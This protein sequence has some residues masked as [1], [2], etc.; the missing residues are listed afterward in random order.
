LSGSGET[1]H[2][3]RRLLARL[4]ALLLIAPSVSVL[5]QSLAHAASACGASTVT[6]TRTSSPVLWEDT[7]T[8]PLVNSMYEAY[9]ITNTSGSA[10]PD[11]WVTTQDFG[12]TAK[13]KPATYESGRTHLGALAAG[14]SK[15]AFFYVT[16]SVTAKNQ[17][18]T[19]AESHNIG[20]YTTRPDLAAGPLCTTASSMY[21]D[22]SQNALANK[23]TSVVSGPKPPQLGGIMTITVSGNTGTV[24]G[25]GTFVTSPAVYPTWPASSYQLTASTIVMTS[26]SATGNNRTDNDTLY[27]VG[28][29]SADSAYTATF[30]FVATGATT[31][32]TTV[33]PMS[34]I[35]SGGLMK[36]TA[37]STT[38][39]A[40][41]PIDP[42]V[43]KLSVTGTL[44]PTSL[45][46]TGGTSTWTL[47][48]KNTGN[49]A[50]TLD[51]ITLGVPTSPGIPAYAGGATF[52]GAAVTGAQTS[53]AS[54]VFPGTWT[55]P[56][57]GTSTFVVP[58][59]LPAASGSYALTAIGHVGS[60]QIDTTEDATDSAAQSRSVT[61]SLPPP[62]VASVTPS[63]GIS[64]GGTSVTVTGTNFTGATAVSFG[65]NAAS[66]FT[67][68]DATHL[69]ATAPS[70]TPLSTV[71]VRV[72][73]GSGTSVVNAADRYSYNAAPNNPPAFTAAA[74]NT[75]QTIHEADGLVQ[76][77]ATDPDG[78]SLTYSTTDPLP[79]GITLTPAGAFSGTAA[80]GS[81]GSYPVVVTVDDGQAAGN[82]TATTSLTIT[83]VAP[84]AAHLSVASPTN[85]PTPDITAT[86][87]AADTAVATLTIGGQTYTTAPSAGALVFHVSTPLG[88]GSYAVNLSVD[89]GL[90]TPATDSATLVVDT[91]P[92]TLTLALP[93]ST[94][95]TTPTISGSTNA[96]PGAIVTVS[97]NGHTYTGPVSASGTFDIDVTDLLTD[98]S[99]AVSAT[100]SDLA[101]N[102]AAATA[103]LVVSTFVPTVTLDHGSL[104]LTQDSSP[105]ISGTTDAADG[106]I[107]SVDVGGLSV[108]GTVS[109]GAF[110]VAVGTT[111][112][113]GDYAVDASVTDGGTGTD[114]QTLRIDTTPYTIGIDGGSSATTNTDPPVISGTTNAPA[115]TTVG[116]VIGATTHTTTATGV[117]T[118]SLTW[119]AALGNGTV[120]VGASVTDAAGNTA[121]DFQ[122]LIVDMSGPSLTIGATV[123]N[124]TTPDVTGTTNAVDGTIVTVTVDGTAFTGPV[125][126]GT[127]AITVGPLAE[128][129]FG[130]TATVSDGLGHATT[131]SS[132]IT[133]DLTGPSVLV[134]GQAV[135]TST[136]HVTGVT[137][138]P[139]GSP[140]TVSV[141]GGT[142]IGVVTSGAFSVPVGPLADATYPVDVT[143][144]DAV[145]NPTVGHGS[146]QVDT[147]GP[148]LTAVSQTTSDP[149]P[150]V[151]GTTDAGTGSTVT[152]VVD[153]TTYVTTV[154][155]GGLYSVPVGPLADGA[156]TVSVT[157]TDA[158]ANPTTVTPSLVVDTTG[159]AVTVP[160]I[161]A[162]VDTV[163]VTATTDAPYATP[164]TVTVDGVDY[165]TSVGFGGVVSV[166]V[167]PLTDGTHGVSVTTTDAL[168]NA[169][170]TTSS[171][172]IDT[173][174]PTVTIVGAPTVITN[175]SSGTFTGTSTEPAG[176]LVTVTVAGVTQTTTVQPDGT[177]SVPW[178][179]LP[180]DGA[181][182]VTVSVTDALG[183]TSTATQTVVID[184]TP[185]VI[186]IDGGLAVTL[187]VTAGSATATITGTTDAAPGSTV[188]V[189]VDGIPYTTVVHG[190]GTYMTTPIP[191]LT[192][193]DHAV[194]V[195]VMDAAGNAATA[196]QTLH[197]HL[198]TATGGPTAGGTGGGTTGGGTGGGTTSGGTT[199][200]GGTTGGTTTGGTTGGTTTGGT[201]DGSGTG[202]AAPGGHLARTGS[203]T[204]VIV[205]VGLL[206][207]LIG[208]T[209]VVAAR[210]PDVLVVPRR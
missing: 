67:I 146:L 199:T 117:G 24:G 79:A 68:V 148:A 99:Y 76:V 172:L 52:N 23:V 47:T 57:G 69:T 169:T 210:R 30:T 147:T 197:V 71:D 18:P 25:A 206:L 107:V 22:F 192:D 87:T 91:T 155:A 7:T 108:S 6:S 174:P 112:G 165:P 135:N 61:V 36:H 110:S 51:D 55:I 5:S 1:T 16:S 186:A 191:G 173:T 44:G 132:T 182:M 35:E 77:T 109:A 9:K 120:T 49:I 166:V 156:H 125:M 123:T 33:S 75:A 204:D 4:T 133:V 56:A 96:H 176:T 162:N 122:Q 175:S 83:V 137:D 183:N 43:S 163:T 27:L 59:T 128:G 126:G 168:G 181:Y 53:A 171:I 72:A 136:T 178:P 8:S 38:G 203:P 12:G 177:Y 46:Y 34:H 101:G 152:V 124:D 20:V 64:H 29:N 70:G 11:L 54:I 3:V 157:V 13:I 200:G 151:S 2:R 50:S 48:L 196:T 188:V 80:T 184:R 106:S 39:A 209:A 201:G 205:A 93:A 116:V 10:Y 73:N 121:N 65:A 15:M 153:G 19:A 28:L 167:G 42:T 89:D 115:G 21:A 144:A 111:L 131:K 154:Q 98:G 31:A 160:A 190:N 94:S 63:N 81:A 134:N 103:T 187:N 14:A 105:S 37:D 142:Y 170:T 179:P 45:P 208:G 92:P 195:S 66:S 138:A 102:P 86:T 100:V 97:V 32:P 143:I 60:T 141:G 161:S 85:D 84:I 58:L 129:V 145:G 185:P 104:W 114:S 180:S 41:P 17:L 95:D 194:T 26:G 149:T 40:L 140:V 130:S 113:D 88:E 207:M 119:A 159:P 78:D 139:D 118:W 82:S 127:Y 193:G 158:L 202:T 74:A 189:V 62:T 150:D 164:V 198:S 90:G